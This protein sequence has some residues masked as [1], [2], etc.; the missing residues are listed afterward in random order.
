MIATGNVKITQAE[1]V[2]T[3]GLVIVD[4]K[5]E[6]V[7]LREDPV[8]SQLGSSLTGKEIIIKRGQGIV[9]VP[10]DKENKVRFIGPSIKDLGFESKKEVKIGEPETEKKTEATLPTPAEAPS[11]PTEVSPSKES[12]KEKTKK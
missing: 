7:I 1:R 5:N 11:K 8:V 6:Q 2:A 3:A 12:T 9:I 10:G 4:P